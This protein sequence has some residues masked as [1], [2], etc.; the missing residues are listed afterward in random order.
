MQQCE[1]M[2]SRLS[3]IVYS[4]WTN[5]QSADDLKD[6]EADS[7]ELL[8]FNHKMTKEEY[9]KREASNCTTL[10]KS[11]DKHLF[12]AREHYS[13]RS[14]TT[15]IL[16]F[17]AIKYFFLSTLNLFISPLVFVAAYT[18]LCGSICLMRWFVAQTGERAQAHG[19]LSLFFQ[20]FSSQFFQLNHMKIYWTKKRIIIK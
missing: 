17:S 11:N 18:K 1:K 9:I 16:W 19:W 14:P 8:R 4:I 15:G 5:R 6:A 20:H 13:L 2:L 12:N 3:W 7:W 10:I